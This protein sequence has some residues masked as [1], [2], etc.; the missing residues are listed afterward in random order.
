MTTAA[1]VIAT[2]GQAM[3]ASRSTGARVACA[4][5][6]CSRAAAL[7]SRLQCPSEPWG[8]DLAQPS[9]LGRSHRTRVGLLR[10]EAA[11]TII[12]LEV[13]TR[14]PQGLA[15]VRRERAPSPR[16]KGRTAAHCAAVCSEPTTANACFARWSGRATYAEPA[17]APIDLRRLVLIRGICIEAAAIARC[18]SATTSMA[19]TSGRFC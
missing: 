10:L 7:R 5:C 6:R 15:T 18:P 3:R 13:E 8:S 14:V 2:V 17:A 12:R 16:S 11:T 9:H 19:T 1:G 4:P